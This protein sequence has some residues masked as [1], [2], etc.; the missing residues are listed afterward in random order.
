MF[1]LNRIGI[2]PSDDSEII[3]KKNFVVYLGA[4][5]S[6]GALIWA[7]LLIFF[8]LPWHALVP[9]SYVVITLV[10]FSSFHKSRHVSNAGFIQG[11]ISICLPFLMQW[12]LGGF[13]A[14]GIVMLWSVI[15]LLGT[16]TFASF[17]LSAFW[18]FFFVLLIFVSWQFE[19]LNVKSV[20][21]PI[22][23]SRVLLIVNL[24][25]VCTAVFGFRF[26]LFTSGGN[27][28][29]NCAKQTKL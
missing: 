24:T 2:A 18:F 22:E 19:Y 1:F 29:M 6:A 9:L 17:R 14:S 16:I 3:L 23:V 27:R 4:S 8:G 21:I 11:S 10:N 5:M 25:L 7:A 26:F 28:T 13:N 15:A 20:H 12:L